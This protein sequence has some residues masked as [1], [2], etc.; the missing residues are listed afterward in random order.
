MTRDCNGAPGVVVVPG[1]SPDITALI[2]ELLHLGLELQH[3]VEEFGDM[4][5]KLSKL[6]PPRG[7]Q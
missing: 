4:V 2:D 3:T 7:D 5:E 1:P 6:L